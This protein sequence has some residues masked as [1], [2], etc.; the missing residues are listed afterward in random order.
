MRHA[1]DFTVLVLWIVGLVLAKGFWSTA[2][3]I[4]FPPWALYLVAERVLQV[5]GWFA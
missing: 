3:G 4:V 5:L 1:F 2:I